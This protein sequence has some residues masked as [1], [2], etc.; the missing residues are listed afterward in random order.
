MNR[1]KKPVAKDAAA[2]KE[3]KSQPLFPQTCLRCKKVYEGAAQSFYCKLCR[4]EVRKHRNRVRRER[5]QQARIRL[6]PNSES[7]LRTEAHLRMHA[8]KNCVGERLVL[9]VME[10]GEEHVF[11]SFPP[12]A[13]AERKGRRSTRRRTALGE[14]VSHDYFTL[15]PFE[16]PQVPVA[17]RYRVL[18]V[19]ADPEHAVI[20]THVV[21]VY[22]DFPV[23][24]PGSPIRF[25]G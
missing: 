8:P 9:L 22:I 10:T 3:K 21:E 2:S 16:I 15:E 6:D 4:P 14:Y 20:P 24:C 18:Y 11:P 1:K 7:I 12:S 23:P 5:E 25:K 19:S 13:L 17:G